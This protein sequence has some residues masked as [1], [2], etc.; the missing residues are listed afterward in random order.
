M[1]IVAGIEEGKIDKGAYGFN[2]F[3]SR[4]LSASTFYPLKRSKTISVN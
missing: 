1:R 4:I 2:V 3:S